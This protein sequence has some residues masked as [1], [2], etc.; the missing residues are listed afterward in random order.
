LDWIATGVKVAAV[1]FALWLGAQIGRAVLGAIAFLAFNAM[2]LGLL[3]AGL[4]VISPAIEWVLRSITLQDVEN[5][6]GQLVDDIIYFF[7]EISQMLAKW[8]G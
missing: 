8:L 1:A 6:F 3:I 4:A 7:T 2:V 5:F